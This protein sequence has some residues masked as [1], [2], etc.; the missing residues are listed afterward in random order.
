[1]QNNKTEKIDKLQK[2]KIILISCGDNFSFFQ[3]K[4]NEIFTCGNN[5]TN[6]LSFEDYYP[7]LKK[8]CN[9]FIIPIQIETFCDLK[10]TK[11]TCGQNH[12]LAIVKDS[13]SNTIT[14]WCWGDNSYGQLGLGMNNKRKP[15]TI[16]N[17]LLE[18][19]S[20]PFDIACGKN[21]SIVCLKRENKIYHLENDVKIEDVVKDLISFLKGI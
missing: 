12:C 21:F 4:N 15:P 14:A 5:D 18:Y 3:S 8:Q 20:L 13:L 1:M 10:V 19:V 6:Q 16:I 2:S 7:N 17:T 11:I 9:D